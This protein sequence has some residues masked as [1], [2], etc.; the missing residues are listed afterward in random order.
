ME[1]VDEAAKLKS[2]PAA[3]LPRDRRGLHKV[4]ISLNFW[5]SS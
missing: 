1:V 2:D 3:C 4:T 5:S